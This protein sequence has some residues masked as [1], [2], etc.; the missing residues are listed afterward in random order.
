MYIYGYAYVYVH[1]YVHV[2]GLVYVRTYACLSMVIA[3][4]TV[5]GH[6]RARGNSMQCTVMSSDVVSCHVI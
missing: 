5:M 1:V 6:D 4:V 2:H 3:M